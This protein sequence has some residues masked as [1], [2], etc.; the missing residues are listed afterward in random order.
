MAGGSWAWRP[1]RRRRARWWLRTGMLLAVIGLRRV[2]CATRTRWEP[3]CLAVGAGLMVT[4]FEVPA[5]AVAF[6]I[7]L[8]IMVVALVRGIAVKGRAAAQAADYWQWH[9]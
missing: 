6:L 1:S 2:V 3:V 4:G 8:G 9:G 7:G 5:A